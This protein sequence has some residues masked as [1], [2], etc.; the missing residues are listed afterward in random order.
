MLDPV[1]DGELR[2]VGRRERDE[3]VARA[4][5]R[6]R[7][8]CGR[9]RASPAGRAS[10]A[11]GGSGATT[12]RCTWA[13]RSSI[14]CEPACQI[15]MPRPPAA[16]AGRARGSRGRPGSSRAAR[17]ASRGRRSGRRSSTTTSSASAIVESR[18]AMMIVVRPRIASRS[19]SRMSASVV[20][21]TDAVASSRMRIR[22]SISERT[23]DRDPLALAAGE[24]DPALA[25]HGL[26]AL[27]QLGD[28]LVRLRSARGRLDRLDRRVR[29]AEG[30][31]VAHG[32][33]E[34]ERVLR[35]DADLAPQ[36]APAD[37][38]NV[39]AVDEDAAGGRVVEA[40]HEGGERRLAGARMADQRDRATGREVEL[41]LL[42]HRPLRFVA[43]RD[44][45]EADGTG[46][47]RKRLRARPVGDL[48]RL[49]EDLEDALAGGGRA[50][51]LADPHP[52][53][54]QRHHQ[55]REQQVEG[56]RSRRARGCRGRRSGRPR[57]GRRACATIGRKV[58][59]G[60]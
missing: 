13:P 40:R 59:S 5:C 22:G 17:P 31:V 49:V 58:S 1:V 53:H 12:S 51:G 34:E 24:R 55:H 29:E 35:D 45:L 38:A 41:D 20:A 37:A 36:R 21:S 60:T 42:E 2:E 14:R 25:D 54:P 50:L 23:R 27:R 47:G 28:E 18:W 33:R 8:P 52:E 3:R 15:F 32:G 46:P 48:L 7:A 26:V 43:E 56:G 39:D 19:P 10:R 44:A 16:A 9:G 11:G 4:A 57:A 6:S 30:D